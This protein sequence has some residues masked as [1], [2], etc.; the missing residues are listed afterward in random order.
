MLGSGATARKVV[1]VA[2]ECRYAVKVL[3]SE[4]VKWPKSPQ[5]TELK[6]S[7]LEAKSIDSLV[8]G[9]TAVINCF[10]SALRTEKPPA[11]MACTTV[12]RLVIAAMR[13]HHIPR[14]I[15][16]SQPSVAL[17]NEQKFHFNGLLTSCLYRLR[18]RS[19]RKD[20][21]AEAS[22]IHDSH[23]QWTLVRCPAIKQLANSGTVKVNRHAP[24]GLSVSIDRLAR[25]LIHQIDSNTYL[26]S[27]IFVSSL[28]TP[29]Y[30]RQRSHATKI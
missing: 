1:D 24:N 4:G 30:L 27:G 2:I 13:R 25:F 6:G 7:L 28:S 17:P 15:V 10:G 9:C 21:L 18:Y 14:Y 22:M 16:V 26:Q 8:A 29:S 12:T 23:L 20:R 19:Q 5:V 3:T 11:P